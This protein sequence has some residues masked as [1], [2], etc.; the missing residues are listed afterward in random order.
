[1][2]QPAVKAG[3]TAVKADGRR[4][5]PP[6]GPL[7]IL[8][9]G[10]VMQ[11]RYHGIGRYAFELLLELSERDVDLIVVHN[12]DTGRL[13]LREL[14]ARP[15][16]RAVPCTV[17]VVSVRTQWVLARATR[18]FRP[19]VVFIPYHLATPVL[20]GTV[21]VV[22]VIHDCIFE[23]HAA[24]GG[25]SAFSVA[26]GAATRLAIRSATALAAPSHAAARDISHFY[27][28][29]LPAGPVLP[30]GVS[31][32]F[33][34]LAGRPRPP[35]LRLPDRYILHVGAQRPHKNQRVLVEALAVL[36]RAHPELGLV[37]VGQPDPR[38]PDDTGRIAE[39][40]GVARHVRR[41]ADLTNATVMDLYANAAVFGYP[42]L[43]E[44]FG[45]PVLEAMAAG[46]PVVASDAEAVREVAGE[47][48]VIVP[49]RATGR[50]VEALDRVLT[51]EDFAR[52]LRERARAVAAGHT[53]AR[54][55][56]RTLD[57]LAS[58]AA[59]REGRGE[60]RA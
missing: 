53:W 13:D 5:G 2:R 44:G 10:R 19:D 42:S 11:D 35:G 7:R 1:M 29:G 31:D 15:A 49:A 34:T 47:G 58:V 50:W 18:A 21:P 39:R 41:Y 40:L 3:R 38:F 14:L 17:P 33:F 32:G 8:V 22:S 55:A 12:P 45:L 4:P 37:L 46:L 26:Y 36:R 48:A 16:V 9:D 56:S 59:C 24:A 27:R 60:R 23:R 30:H 51:D 52:G 54:S 57:M 20:H 6:A 25:R 28:P 43:I